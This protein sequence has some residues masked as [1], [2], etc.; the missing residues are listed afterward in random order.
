MERPWAWAWG[1][2]YDYFEHHQH[3]SQVEER[4]LTVSAGCFDA[5]SHRPST[6]ESTAAQLKEAPGSRPSHIIKIVL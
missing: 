3:P 4:T 5:L 1:T 6:I 2:L